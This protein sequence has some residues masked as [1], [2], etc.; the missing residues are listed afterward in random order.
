MTKVLIALDESPVSSRAARTATRLFASMPDV[1][2]L[3]INVAKV[4]APWV[5][6]AGFGSVAPL[7]VDPRWLQEPEGGHHD[8]LDLMDRAS[9][10][11]V[12]DPEPIARSGD[13][14]TEICAAAEDRDV[15]VIVVGS[16]DKTA[17]GRLLDPSVAAGVVRDTHRPVLVISGQSPRAIA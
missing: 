13:P 2:F 17:L 3:V 15:D 14:V 11:G 9:S 10:V 8:E 12:P 6:T 4:P 1:E 16:H 7:V 5:G